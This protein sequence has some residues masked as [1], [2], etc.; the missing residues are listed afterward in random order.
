M[1]ESTGLRVVLAD[2][3]PVIRMGLRALCC[4]TDGITVVGEAAGERDA[5][6]EV[7]L[8]RPDVLVTELCLSGAAVMRAVPGVAVLVF[9][10]SGDDTSLRAAIR[11]GARGYV[12]KGADESALRRIV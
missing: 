9:T 1:T 3:D 11:S 6:R 4:A 2:P 12:L 7:R 10:A 5:V 8:H